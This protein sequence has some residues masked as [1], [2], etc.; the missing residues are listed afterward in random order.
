M[1][2]MVI[3]MQIAGAPA[4]WGGPFATILLFRR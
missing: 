2:A 3:D 1:D 4:R